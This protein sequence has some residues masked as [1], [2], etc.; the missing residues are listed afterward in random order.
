MVLVLILVLEMH[1]RFV[2]FPLV[3]QMLGAQQESPF[4]HT[5]HASE[6]ELGEGVAFVV[7]DGGGVVLGGELLW[8]QSL[9]FPTHLQFRAF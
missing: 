5:G 2:G 4:P 7:G 1:A 8:I 3:S 9:S 6:G